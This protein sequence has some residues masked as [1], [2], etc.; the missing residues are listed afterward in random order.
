MDHFFCKLFDTL[1]IGGGPHN[2]TTKFDILEE[3][4]KEIMTCCKTCNLVEKKPS[5]CDELSSD[6]GNGKYTVYF[7]EKPPL[8]P[9]EVY[10]D[11]TTDGGGWTV[12]IKTICT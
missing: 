7:G 8:T 12:C 10:C 11:M 3:E 2:C 1:C 4:L 5:N 6:T 9:V